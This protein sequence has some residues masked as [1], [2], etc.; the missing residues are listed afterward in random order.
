MDEMVIQI[1]DYLVQLNEKNCKCV[2]AQM[3][4]EEKQIL[5]LDIMHAG[6]ADLLK[7]FGLY[8][9]FGEIRYFISCVFR[10]SAGVRNPKGSVSYPSGTNPPKPGI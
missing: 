6:D 2:V 5:L 10:R 9:P 7:G 4:D 3:T 1:K 8:I